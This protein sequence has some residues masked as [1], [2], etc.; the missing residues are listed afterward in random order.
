M[1]KAVLLNWK[2]QTEKKQKDFFVLYTPNDIET[3]TYE[4]DT[5]KPWLEKF[6]LQNKI[7]F[8]DPRDNLL[9]IQLNGNDVFYDHYTKFGH[10]AVAQE[11]IEWYLINHN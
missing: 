9:R 10:D 11:F 7:P 1:G 5:W 4:Q 3:P 6:C 8:I 2:N